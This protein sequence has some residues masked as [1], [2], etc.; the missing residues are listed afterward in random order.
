[1][2]ILNFVLAGLIL[3]TLAFS[4]GCASVPAL[5]PEAVLEKAYMRDEAAFES[6]FA[7]DLEAKADAP[8]VYD[9]ARTATLRGRETDRIRVEFDGGALCS[10]QYSFFFLESIEAFSDAFR[11]ATALNADASETF[12]SPISADYFVG[13]ESDWLSSYSAADDLVFY[14]S[15]SAEDIHAVADA[16]LVR[17][18]C[19]LVV[20]LSTMDDK[21]YVVTATYAK[22]IAHTLSE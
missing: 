16:Y 20:N 8:G 14:W 9:L 2:R 13:S 19:V 6:A 21:S 15:R 12:G 1:M 4:P 5:S 3:L 18:D 10:I 22:P 7:L 17:D 11:F